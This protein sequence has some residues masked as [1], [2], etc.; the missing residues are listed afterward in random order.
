MTTGSRVLKSLTMLVS[1]LAVGRTATPERSADVYYVTRMGDKFLGYTAQKEEALNKFGAAEQDRLEEAIANAPAEREKMLLETTARVNEESRFEVQNAFGEMRNFISTLKQA[2][3]AVGSASR[4]QDLTCGSHAYCTADKRFGARCLCKEGYSGNGFVCKT[5]R[6]LAAHSLMQNHPGME[7]PRLS[8][9]H[10]SAIH[11]DTILAVYRDISDSHRGYAMLGRAGPTNMRWHPPVLFSNESKAFAPV[12]VHLQE[13]QD[14]KRSGGIA[15]AFRNANH[16]GD[17]LILGGRISPTTGAVSF[18]AAKAFARHQS[19]AVV[20]LP[21]SDSRVAIFFA[22]RILGAGQPVG[23]AMYGASLLAKVHSSRSM[24]EILSKDRF[25]AGPVAQISALAI[26]PSVFAIAYRGDAEPG[27]PQAEAACIAGH[28]ARGHIN[29]PSQAFLLE[30]QQTNIWSRSLA[31]TGK[32]TFSYTYHSGNEKVTKQAFLRVEPRTH[33]LELLE[34]PQV[35]ARGV[36]TEVGS[37]SLLP[38]SEQ[39]TTG[40]FPMSFLERRRRVSPKLLTYVGNSRT[41]PAEAHI[42]KMSDAGLPFGCEAL[43]WAG[44][45]FHSVAGAQVSDGRYVF[46]FVDAEGKPSY[47]F[48]GLAEHDA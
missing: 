39:K 29:Y 17:G 32:G 25:V 37:V 46:M 36:H 11:G 26:S 4:C 40:P 12:L 38:D 2:M 45:D 48:V 31:S 18:G 22:E 21:L 1:I 44:R 24:P 14:G 34:E 7:P 9:I 33:K 16:G 47:D 23:G 3:G 27:S 41:E 10:V 15:I 8:D 42:C 43:N 19:Q 35:I 28:L 6:R 5:S 13:G 30:P 20:M